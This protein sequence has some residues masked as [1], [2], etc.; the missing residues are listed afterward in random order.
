MGITI[1]P[2]QPVEVLYTIEGLSRND[3][4]IIAQCVGSYGTDNLKRAGCQVLN[5]QQDYLW[6][7]F[8]RF[9]KLTS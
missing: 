5:G 7:V 3:L 1:K 2:E 9:A 4:M 6:E 8:R